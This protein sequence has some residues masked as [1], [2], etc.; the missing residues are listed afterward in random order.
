M[1]ALPEHLSKAIA[2]LKNDRHRK[3]AA[4]YLQMIADAKP[5]A[6]E[7]YRQAGFKAK[8][9]QVAAASADQLLRRPE[10][11]AIVE[12]AREHAKQASTQA[13]EGAIGDLSW[14]RQ[15][16]I[17]ITNAGMSRLTLKKGDTVIEGK[18]VDLTVAAKA[19][20]VLARIDGDEKPIKVDLRAHES[21]LDL[22]E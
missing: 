4:A 9:P 15:K 14:K 3:F 18:Y 13:V 20:Q 5:N 22:L 8:T 6:A 2:A 11:K 21:V 16:L 7:A 12:A 17:E 10:I 19:I 1:T